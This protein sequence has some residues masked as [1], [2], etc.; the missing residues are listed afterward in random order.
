MADYVWRNADGMELHSDRE[1]A[2]H[3]VTLFKEGDQTI[4]DAFAEWVTANMHPWDALF[5]D[6]NDMLEVWADMLRDLRPDLLERYTGYALYEV[7][8]RRVNAPQEVD[9]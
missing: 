3:V 4:T 5:S 9:A 1:M 6:F 7:E 2:A 8:Y